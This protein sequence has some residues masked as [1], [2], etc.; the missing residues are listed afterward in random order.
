[1]L[2]DFGT[3]QTGDFWEEYRTNYARYDRVFADAGGGVALA[4]PLL[5][6]GLQH[7]NRGPIHD[8][9]GVV[10]IK[11]VVKTAVAALTVGFQKRNQAT[12]RF[13]GSF[14]AFQRKA[15]HVHAGQT[16]LAVS[17]LGENR[18]IADA[19]TPF[20]DTHLRAPHPGR[21]GQKHSISF[22][23]LGNGKV[24]ARH[25]AGQPLLRPMIFQNL[26]L[27]GAPVRIF[28][29]KGTSFTKFRKFSRRNWLE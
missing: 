10:V 19:Q 4:D 28:S 18:L 14:A 3:G 26:N 7:K 23:H 15:D 24:G 6:R 1:M 2:S 11:I 29:K 20:V 13:F 8:Q 16:R 9:E 17:A 21:T 22:L 12:E 27:I 5:S 25:I